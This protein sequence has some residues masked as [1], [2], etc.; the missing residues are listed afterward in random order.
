MPI[1]FA[2][3]DRWVTDELVLNTN[4]AMGEFVRKIVRKD[5]SNSTYVNVKILDAFFEFLYGTGISYDARGLHSEIR[6]LG[7]SS[8]RHKEACLTIID[9]MKLRSKDV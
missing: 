6:A 3:S 8:P 1:K 4:E 9:H 5:I 2:N 7:E